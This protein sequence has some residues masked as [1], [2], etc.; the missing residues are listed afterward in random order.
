[1]RQYSFISTFFVFCILLANTSCRPPEIP[2]VKSSSLHV[3]ME[4]DP[5]S[6]DP[7][8]VRDLSTVTVIHMLYEGLMRSGEDGQPLLALAEEVTIS[9]D[10]KTYTFQLRPSSWSNGEPVT[11]RDFEA[12]WKSVLD[13]NFVS[14]NAYQLYVI[15]GAQSAKEKRATLDQV[16]V[17][18]QND[19][20][21]VVELERPTP[22]FFHLLATHFF[23]PVHSS[24]RQQ[25]KDMS[26]LPNSK[27]LTNGPFKLENW[28]HH[29]ELTAVPNA[30]YWDKDQVSLE[31]IHLVVVD[32]RTALQL[33][34]RGELDWTGSP[35]STLSI[36]AL[37]SLR[38][39]DKLHIT[40]AAG[41]YLFRINTEKP[42]LNQ[43]KMRRALALALNRK[44]LVDHVLRGNQQP[45]YG[46]IPPSFIEGDPLFQDYDV[47]LARQLFQEV[48]KEQNLSLKNIPQITLMY[49]SGE[50]PHKIAQVA[51]QQWKTNLGLEVVL[52]SSEPKVYFEHLKNKNYQLGISS[53]F[54]DFRDP[55]SFLEIF[56]LK[57][58]GTN[59]T[60]WEN[61]KYV[62]LLDQSA[63]SHQFAHRKKILKEAENVLVQEMPVIPL[64]YSSY[65][66][67]KDPKI[68]GIYFSELGYLDFKN[69][70]WD[71][72]HSQD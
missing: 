9:P 27:I 48:L 13:P 50:R 24:S 62:T 15:R 47:T 29:N 41:V 45:A 53:W 51:Q 37:E 57:E 63:L 38:N 61:P 35:L 25:S 43:P 69:A 55:I 32:N 71:T 40:P 67:V 1:M 49:A 11:A 72:G 7:R 42:L 20:T 5:L 31:R 12:T 34:E 70:Y 36:D 8:R 2:K 21:L 68:K 14:P 18:A 46:L 17:H 16:G 39:K 59:N 30:Y 3:S 6:L 52:Q 64:F 19:S 65:N 23:L 33:F 58:N 26:E 28:S 22:Y 54:A 10:R 4:S 66:Y 44:E 56:K 60:Q